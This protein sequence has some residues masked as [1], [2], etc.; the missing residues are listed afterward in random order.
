MKNL[1][2]IIKAFKEMNEVEFEHMAEE[3][4]SK[5]EKSNQMLGS[6][7]GI[8]DLYRFVKN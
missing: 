7:V 5:C 3:L 6:M 8:E 2:V 4:M 1:A